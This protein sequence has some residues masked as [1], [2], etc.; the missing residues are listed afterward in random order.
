MFSEE[1]VSE[2]ENFKAQ[3]WAFYGF[4][5]PFFRQESGCGSCEKDQLMCKNTM[6]YV[7]W[8]ITA[9]ADVRCYHHPGIF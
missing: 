8:T 4:E 2:S 7:G 3:K 6:Q 5:R 1:L 9:E